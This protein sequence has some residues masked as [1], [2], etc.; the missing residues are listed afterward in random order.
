MTAEVP[1]DE[2]G[3]YDDGEE[4]D[5]EDYGDDDECDGGSES[6]DTGCGCIMFLLILAVCIAIWEALKYT[7]FG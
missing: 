2:I 4:E 7:F 5:E 3:D 1:K 6:D